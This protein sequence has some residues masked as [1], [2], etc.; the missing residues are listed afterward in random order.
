MSGGI[1]QLVAVGQ[2]NMF[3]TDDPQITFFKLVYRRHTN[4]SI[5]QIPQK[6]TELNPDF[7]MKVSCPIS[8]NGDLINNIGLVIEL[9]E[10]RQFNTSSGIDNITTFQWVRK[11]GYAIIKSVEIEINGR[12][13]DRHYGEWLSL[14]S[15]MFGPKDRGI[16]ILTG[17]VPELYNPTNGKK[18]YKLYIP[19]QFWFCKSSGLA[20]PLV[21]LEYSDININ[22]HFND[23]N[24][25]HIINPTH[26][27]FCDS[28]VLNSGLVNFIEGEYIEQI[29]NGTL[30]AG[31]FNYYDITTN[32]LYY[33]AIT[34]SIFKGITTTAVGT[35]QQELLQSLSNIQYLITG[36]TS[37]FTVMPGAN[38][39]SLTY[40]YNPLRNIK[41]NNAY[42]IVN[43]IFVDDD[44]RIKI[45]QAKH[46]YLIDQLYFT[47]NITLDGANRTVKI[48][49]DQ[50]TEFMT[51]IVQMSYIYKSLDYYNYTDSYIRKISNSEYPDF[52]IGDVVGNSIILKQTI[53]LNSTSRLSQRDAD[54]FYNIQNYQYCNH[55]ITPKTNT[56]S[57]ALFPNSIQPSGTCNMSQM[58]KTEIVLNLSP[59][60]NTTNPVIFRC[61]CNSKNILRI[62]NGL[63]ALVFVSNGNNGQ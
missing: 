28:T 42:L 54:Y 5:E 58:T 48:V 21:C 32:K 18:A 33:T 51:W 2:E 37:G 36:K 1:I 11:I 41:L 29:I 25:C 13:I 53:D 44:E 50:P 49:A 10:I 61:Y 46:D 19:L 12:T 16:D 27:I 3:L 40:Q 31:I 63:A 59:L 45:A 38:Q 52:K 62:Q 47:P 6:F 43:Y 57:F 26:Y 9:P 20:L 17:N 22:I 34:S 60:I 24:N 14:L 56:Y 55:A 4:F 39:K 30:Y 8:K 23:L 35:E 15:D 7:G